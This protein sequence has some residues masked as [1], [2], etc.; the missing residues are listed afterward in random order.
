[1]AFRNPPP[2]PN[3]I[4]SHVDGYIIFVAYQECFSPWFQSGLRVPPNQI[5][6]LLQ[7]RAL[8]L[9]C[10]CG[11]IP[12]AF[13]ST[14]KDSLLNGRFVAMC[15]RKECNYFI[16]LTGA[17]DEA[18]YL[19]PVH[20]SNAAPGMTNSSS[21]S[22]STTRSSSSSTGT[23]RSSN[24][25]T[26]SSNGT[27]NSAS[28]QRVKDENRSQRGV[29]TFAGY[30]T[31]NNP[32]DL[33]SPQICD[34]G[35]IE[36]SPWYEFKVLHNMT[37]QWGL[38]AQC[39]ACSPVLLS[40]SVMNKPTPA[41]RSDI[42]KLKRQDSLYTATVLHGLQTI[43]YPRRND[44]TLE[45]PAQVWTQLTDGTIV[46]RCFHCKPVLV[47]PKSG[48]MNGMIKVK[49]PFSFPQECA[50][51]ISVDIVHARL[52]LLEAPI[53]HALPSP[54]SSPTPHFSPVFDN[55][56]YFVPHYYNY[57]PPLHRNSSGKS[58]YLWSPQRHP[59]NPKQSE[60]TKKFIDWIKQ[61]S[62]GTLDEDGE[63]V[64]D[65]NETSAGRFTHS[66]KS[67]GIIVH[68]G[69]AKL[70]PDREPDFSVTRRYRTSPNAL[71]TRMIAERRADKSMFNL[72]KGLPMIEDLLGYF[73]THE[74]EIYMGPNNEIVFPKPPVLLR[75]H[76]MKSELVK[77]NVMKG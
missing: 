36:R 60:S 67:T 74:N 77:G 44:G 25:T 13:R 20:S 29:Q 1:M 3:L 56:L 35:T 62:D 31:R 46:M 33:S 71:A 53:N 55:D 51:K 59:P 58:L 48:S 6:K 61:L 38:Q 54:A 11:R 15:K 40:N 32:I 37:V 5:F 16:D 63:L 66:F 10:F 72:L 70:F 73:E 75:I 17:Y 47:K 9:E 41:K 28:R 65:E 49:C 23:M 69:R 2:R 21:S 12:S 26:R 39:S 30:G 8:D 50:F 76:V 42:Q 14:K 27:T 19:W 43:P 34:L 7:T 57:V 4:A 45:L 52:Q 64:Y 24:T 18:S 68:R 22:T